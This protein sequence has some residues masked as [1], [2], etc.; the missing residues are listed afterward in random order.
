[1]I[2]RAILATL[3]VFG[4]TVCFTAQADP[5]KEESGD[6]YHHDRHYRK[7]HEG[8]HERDYYEEYRVE[9]DDRG[10]PPWA[11]AHG[12][13]RKHHHHHHRESTTVIVEAP[14][15]EQPQY[16]EVVVTPVEEAPEV[17]FELASQQI[18]ITAG[19]CN[20]EAVG[21]LMGG[22]VGGVIGNNV[23]RG[24]NKALGTFAGAI[25]GVVLGKELGRNMDKGDAQCTSQILERARDGQAVVWDNPQTRRHYAVTPYRTYKRNDGRYCRQYKAIVRSGSTENVFHQT[26]C[27]N[28]SGVWQ[29]QR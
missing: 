20:R 11:P 26:A 3:L 27:R 1:M 24:D 23:S 8:Q 14:V 25:I 7:H 6:G 10:P 17:Q 4:L 19:T 9:D 29:R 15:R 12:Y 2:I 21:A 22:I 5:W 13:R 28:D 16:R 18:G